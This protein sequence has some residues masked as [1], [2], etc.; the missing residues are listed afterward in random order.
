M[1]RTLIIFA[2]AF[3][4]LL[5]AQTVQILDL[6]T[7][8][9]SLGKVILSSVVDDTNA[10]TGTTYTIVKADAYRL[11]TFSNGASIA[12]TLPEA[13]TLGFENGRSF[14]LK[15]LG[16]G[17]VTVTPTT[18]TIDG[19]A[20]L[21]ILSD[22]FAVA[23]SDGTN[24]QAIVGD[25]IGIGAPA[26]ATY[27]T[28]TANGGLS[29]EQAMGA[30]AT[31]IVKN[32]TTTGV[33]SI[34]GAAD[35]GALSPNLDNTDASVEWEDAGDLESD[36]ALSNDVVAPD[37]MADE[38]HGDVSW[39]SGVATVEEVDEAAVTNHEGAIDHDALKNFEADE[40]RAITETAVADGEI[41][42]FKTDHWENQTLV[43]WGIQ[44]ADSD[45]DIYAGI[46]P[47]ANIQTFLGAADYAAMVTQLSLV[48]G[49]N[50]Q[51]Y[52]ADLD[53]YAGITPSSNIQTFLGA[54][55]YA[56]MITQLS[57]VI[58]TNV[59]AYDADLT[60]YAGITPSAN[61]QT[62]LGAAD[63]AAMRTALGLI[64]G[65]DVQDYDTDLDIYSGITP[66]SNI[67]TLLGAADYAAMRT[68]LGLVIGT[69]VLAYDAAATT[70]VASGANALDTDAI[71][72]TACDT[73]TP[74]TATG[75]VSTDVVSWTPNA[76]ITAVTGYVPVTAGGLSIYL[77]PD[78][79][80][81]GVKVCNPTSSTIT[82]GA[83]TLNWKVIR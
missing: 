57:L 82:P 28:Q 77:W 41:L 8:S 15:N 27:I 17:V 60:T 3:A 43:E 83:V 79:D 53:T 64:I 36:G 46:T 37:E 16:A 71:T 61:I 12:V 48:I 80:V 70:L 62:L 31:G 59:Q 6:D 13:G 51:A 69:N 56:A 25:G 40:H 42:G 9:V 14:I 1:M 5:P 4:C 19:S 67:Q 21:V 2:F 38:D 26:D 22:G 47:S 54:A 65:T 7:G 49:A 23:W 10:Q 34:A 18:S 33:Q 52:D 63:Y 45:L 44:A 68:Q 72:T 30:L 66:S 35:I 74:F 50:V 73:I 78:T 39:A 55:D 32:T 58:G 29:A 76:D 75:V 11:T 24:Y 81:I 20:T